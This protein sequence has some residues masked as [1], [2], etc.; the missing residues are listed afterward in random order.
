MDDPIK[1]I[2]PDWLLDTTKAAQFLGVAESTIRKWVSADYIPHIKLGRLV[3]FN[4]HSLEK[5]LRKIIKTHCSHLE[6][7]EIWIVLCTCINVL[8]CPFCSKRKRPQFMR[9][10]IYALA[11]AGLFGVSAPF[12]K[13]LLS[14]IRP[15]QLAGLLYL[16]S[17]TGLLI[18]KFLT[19]RFSK[20]EKE[21][22]LHGKDYYWLFYA[23]I[24]GGVLAPILLMYGLAAIQA[25]TASLLLNFE[26]V[27]TVLIAILLFKEHVSHR[28][29]FAALMI[30]IAGIL[31][32][33][34]SDGRWGFSWGAITVIGACLLW[35]LD[36]NFTRNISAKNPL[37]IAIIKSF[38]AGSFSFLLSLA[39]GNQLPSALT[40][41]QA[42]V[43]GII[44]Y[45]ASL[46][47]F[48]R[49]LRE[50]GSARTGA[51]FGTA[52]FIGALVSFLIFGYISSAL[53]WI[54]FPI[55]VL[56]AI[57]MLKESHEHFHIHPKIIH[58][59]HHG[60]EDF[61]H[62]HIHP[63]EEIAP[64]GHSHPHAHP[65]T[66]HGHEHSPDIHHRHTHH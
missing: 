29:L 32:T 41:I 52:P 34:E 1:P 26:A 35:G 2:Q 36:N 33:M 3:R 49:A 50:T 23:I 10:K 12:A 47:L 24:T 63:S 51:L 7:S 8:P 54:S 25:S 31:L 39:L 28:V 44:S 38:A 56:G 6:S 42:M 57:L 14:E 4:A 66:K 37:D 11:A 16:E 43:L 17:G 18:V 22:R 48:I 15:V 64:D 13:L 55:M 21:A 65:E 61:H 5:W 20:K 30:T 58:E 60:H 9:G 19:N 62:V 53:F 45:G 40:I 27:G 46:V 59:H